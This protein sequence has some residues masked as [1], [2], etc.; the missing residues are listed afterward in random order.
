M[1]A[2]S[3]DPPF[4]KNPTVKAALE[5]LEKEIRNSGTLPDPLPQYS[6]SASERAID[7]RII[8]INNKAEK[9]TKALEE[10]NTA[11]TAELMEL[12]KKLKR[13]PLTYPQL[14]DNRSS[15]FQYRV[16]LFL[17]CSLL[18]RDLSD[19]STWPPTAS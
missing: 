11:L 5:A 13:L 17:K 9:R 4:A 12:R 8:L 16:G 19:F 14:S 7:E 2:A 1:N 6:P 18:V 15:G 3:P 10:R